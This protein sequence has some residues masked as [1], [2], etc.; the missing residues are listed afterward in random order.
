MQVEP[1]TVLGGRGGVVLRPVEVDEHV[2]GKFLS[3]DGADGAWRLGLG[4]QDAATEPVCPGG[5]R[6]GGEG[7]PGALEDDVVR[8]A[9]VALTRRLGGGGGRPAQ[10]QSARPLQVPGEVR[11]SDNLSL[12]T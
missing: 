11:G 9:G 7:G 3:V 4:G 1:H 5:R 12:M 8:G 2:E 10:L 6:G